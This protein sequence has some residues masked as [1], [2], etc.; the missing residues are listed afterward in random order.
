ML[1]LVLIGAAIAVVGLAL[2][3]FCGAW[4]AD[5]KLRR[6][7]AEV[8]GEIVRLRAVTEE[9]LSGD[10]PKLDD[11][12]DDLHSAANKA[13]AAIQAMENQAAITR[14]KSDGSKEVI[15]S[16]RHIIRMIDEYSGAEPEPLERHVIQAKKPEPKLAVEPIRFIDE[17]PAEDKASAEDRAPVRNPAEDTAPV[18]IALAKKRSAALQQG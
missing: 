2:D 15:A 16:S 14:R 18:Q 9:K 11:I 10:D 12:L 1:D 6:H 3:A 7:Y 4:Y 13:Y 5:K 17:A 8:R